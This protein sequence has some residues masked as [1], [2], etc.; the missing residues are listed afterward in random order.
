MDVV[1]IVCACVA[2]S[3]IKSV[4]TMDNPMDVSESLYRQSNIALGISI[5]AC[6]INL[7]FLIIAFVTVYDMIMNGNLDQYLNGLM[8]SDQS[9]VGSGDGSVWDR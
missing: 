9:S 2:R 5:A 4:R 6:I 7:V 8:G 1:A 3:K